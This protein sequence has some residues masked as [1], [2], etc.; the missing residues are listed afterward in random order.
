MS[1][2][3]PHYYISSGHNSYL[4]GNQLTSKCHQSIIEYAV[5]LGCR[6]IELDVWS[7]GVHHRGEPQVLHGH[8]LTKPVSFTKCV[9]AIKAKFN[10]EQYPLILTIENHC[11]TKS[12]HKMAEILEKHLGDLIFRPDH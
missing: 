4:T 5:G 12:M 9:M 8:T 3:L 2:P 11:N 6:V 10:T 7:G 1:K